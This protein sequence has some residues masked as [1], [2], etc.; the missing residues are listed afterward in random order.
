MT[1]ARVIGCKTL[2]IRRDPSS[3]DIDIRDE[4]VLEVHEGETIN[5][6]TS[7]VLY[8]WKGNAYHPVKCGTLKGYAIVGAL[9]Y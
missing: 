3:E 9:E 2:G 1:K 4:I 7:M 6:N 5:V 8:D